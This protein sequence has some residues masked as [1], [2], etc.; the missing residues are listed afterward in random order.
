VQRAKA[1]QILDQDV[2]EAISDMKKDE[3]RRALEGAHDSVALGIIEN[4]IRVDF[5]PVMAD[6]LLLLS[7]VE[8]TT[9]LAGGPI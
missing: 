3:Y 6:K 2:K 5:Q 7:E 4:K 8:C 1:V 9:A